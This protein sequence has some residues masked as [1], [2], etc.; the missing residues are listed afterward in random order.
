MPITAILI[1]LLH[2]LVIELVTIHFNVMVL[3]CPHF[4]IC[5][6]LNVSHTGHT[7]VCQQVFEPGSLVWQ[8]GFLPIKPSGPA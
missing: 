2:Q 6:T 4:T 7:V 1:L 3:K 5:I 8:A